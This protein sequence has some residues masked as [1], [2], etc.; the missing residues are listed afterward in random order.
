MGGRRGGGCF[1]EGLEDG[2]GGGDV[3]LRIG[4]G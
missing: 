4:Q 3:V 1:D 2:G